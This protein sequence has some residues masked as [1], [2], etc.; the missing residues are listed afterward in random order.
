[1]PP[2]VNR[3]TARAT[4]DAEPP[5]GVILI[6]P[7]CTASNALPVSRLV[8]LR[9]GMLYENDFADCPF[10]TIVSAC[11]AAVEVPGVKN[12]AVPVI[13]ESVELTS[14]TEVVHPAPS[15]NC[16]IAMGALDELVS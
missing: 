15:A 8:E 1:M 2:A 10:T 7:V 12:S 6:Q 5:A 16:G 13:A 3:K 14:R 11:P 4:G 9:G